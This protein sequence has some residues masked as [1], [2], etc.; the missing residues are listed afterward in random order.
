MD[1]KNLVVDLPSIIPPNQIY[2]IFVINKHDCTSFPSHKNFRAKRVL[3]LMHDDIYST[4][5][6]QI[7]SYL[8]SPHKLHP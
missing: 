5:H 7:D 6:K 4:I 1:D 3:Q 2:E 8:K